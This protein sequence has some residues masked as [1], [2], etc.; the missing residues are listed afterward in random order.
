MLNSDSPTNLRHNAP[1]LHLSGL[2]KGPKRHVFHNLGGHV[3]GQ[4]RQFSKTLKILFR[5]CST[6]LGDPIS[7][8]KSKIHEDVFWESTKN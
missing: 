3:G 4:N 2:L 8:K 5:G 7:E 1:A 6:M